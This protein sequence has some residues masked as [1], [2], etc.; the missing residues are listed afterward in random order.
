[1]LEDDELSYHAGFQQPRGSA[2]VSGGRH[3]KQGAPANKHIDPAVRGI[4]HRMKNKKVHIDTIVSRCKALDR[5]QDGLIHISD[6][7]DL[8]LEYL[9]TDGISRREME[10][11]GRLLCPVNAKDSGSID[12]QKLHDILAVYDTEVDK[13]REY[14]SREEEKWYDPAEMLADR[15]HFRRGS[16]GDWLQ[17]A[18]CPAEVKNFRRFIRCLEEFE[19]L[20]GMKCTATDDGFNVPL[21]PDLKANISFYMTG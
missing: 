2:A 20:S 19:R 5:N 3:L 18:A 4:A 17:N 7:E 21:G 12:Y 9:G 16:V 10:H 1:M 6:L 13:R 15:A 14:L 11:L 8:L